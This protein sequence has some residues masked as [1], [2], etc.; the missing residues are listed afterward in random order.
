MFELVI[1]IVCFLL[2]LS[3]FIAVPVVLVIRL[4]QSIL[5][6]ALKK[7]GGSVEEARE[8][9]WQQADAPERERMVRR[10]C[11]WRVIGRVASAGTLVTGASVLAS[12]A[13]AIMSCVVGW[14]LI[15][16]IR[17]EM[18][19]ACSYGSTGAKDEPRQG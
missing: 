17:Q 6:P 16:P 5:G 19:D 13:V 3:V 15:K 4:T 7:I 1:A 18:R 14:R 12:P 9:D 2:V 8:H 11:G 10:A